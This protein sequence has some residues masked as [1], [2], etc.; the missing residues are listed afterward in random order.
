MK[1]LGLDDTRTV[2]HQV[3][4]MIT[5]NDINP[6]CYIVSKI[7]DVEPLGILKLS[8]KLDEFNPKRD[9]V[10]LKICDYYSDS[11]DII[12][13][14]P[15]GTNDPC[16]TSTIYYMKVNADGELEQS[17]E[18]TMLTIGATYYWAVEFSDEDITAQ[19]RIKLIDDEEQYT[20]K[21][22]L[23][24]ERLMVIRDVS[25]TIISLRPGK[26]NRLKGL[27]FNLIVCDTD[28]DYESKIELE[29]EK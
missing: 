2:T 5:V 8:L 6:S 14:E 29:V 15:T 20:E 24:L 18:V 4:S 26:S 11:G 7:L 23:E 22:R 17:S 27:S 21:E 10:A 16:K 1:D 19:W 12:I 25:D 9:N 13:E 3:R 28:G